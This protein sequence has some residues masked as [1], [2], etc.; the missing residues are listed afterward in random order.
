MRKCILPLVA[1]ALVAGT[2]QAYLG[3]VVSSF[4][5]PAGRNTRGLARA[6]E[7]LYIIDGPQGT[8]YQTQP[9]TGSIFKS[10]L[11]YWISGYSGLAFS[12]PSYLWVGRFEPTWPSQNTYIYRCKAG[13]GSIYGSWLSYQD[14]Y[15]LAPWCT[16]D[17]GTGT[18]FIFN[19]DDDPS[20]LQIHRIENGLVAR[21]LDLV[22]ET[23][24][25]CAFDWRNNLIWRGS[26]GRIYGV[27]PSGV[28]TASFPSPAGSPRGLAYYNQYLWIACTATRFVY[29]VHCPHNF[30]AVAPASVGRVKALFR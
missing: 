30:T 7:Y 25:D 26:A 9:S 18:S 12:T 4:R 14:P 17:G 10:Y 2:A 29:R 28:V 19:T 1:V 15:G 22:N 23:K 27:T 5:S 16:G 3:E 6:R 20:R 11:L 24:C 13:T 21:R 8:V